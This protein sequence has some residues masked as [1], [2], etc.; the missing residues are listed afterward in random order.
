MGCATSE[1]SERARTPDV[2]EAWPSHADPSDVRGDW[3]ESLQDAVLMAMVEEAITENHE[4]ARLAE[5]VRQARE[6]L[7]ITSAARWPALSA[8][9]DASRRDAGSSVSG[10]GFVQTGGVLDSFGAS[11]GIN[12]EVDFL[13]KMSDDAKRA[14]FAFLAR[15]AAFQWARL[16]L[17]SEVAS[18]YYSHR[19][20]AELLRLSTRRRQNLAANLDI[21]ESGY[22]QGINSA[23]DVYLSRSVLAQQQ[24]QVAEQESMLT[25]RGIRLQR[26]LGRVPDGGLPSGA[27]L[28]VIEHP[29]PVGLPSDLLGRRRT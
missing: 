3:L 13:L 21:I 19:E 5:E 9:L 20:A 17:V 11:L 22:R 2:P 18:A 6:T 15:E 27:D 16:G 12:W 7:R 29:I 26:L 10:S 24:A 25:E 23:V 1:L 8:S 4:L 28:E 14:S